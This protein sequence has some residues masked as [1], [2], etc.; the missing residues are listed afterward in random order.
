[1]ELR[2]VILMVSIIVRDRS[3]FLPSTSSAIFSYGWSGSFSLVVLVMVNDILPKRKTL[4]R[5]F[6]DFHPRGY[7]L[8]SWWFL[9]NLAELDESLGF[10]LTAEHCESVLLF[11]VFGRYATLVSVGSYLAQNAGALNTLGEALDQV[12]ATFVRVFLYLYVYHVEIT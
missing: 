7:I 6:S 12:D 9:E 10:C 1:M 3:Y 11:G 8:S 2:F 4:E 5:G